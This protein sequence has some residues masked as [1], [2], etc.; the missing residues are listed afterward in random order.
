MPAL[1]IRLLALLVFS[2]SAKAC[3]PQDIGKG[4][5]ADGKEKVADV[6]QDQLVDRN[7]PLSGK[8]SERMS[9]VAFAVS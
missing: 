1:A 5:L 3:C 9:D 8:G 7:I 2:S 6:L 4:E